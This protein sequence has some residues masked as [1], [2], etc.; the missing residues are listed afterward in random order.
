MAHLEYNDNNITHAPGRTPSLTGSSQHGNSD[1]LELRG[2]LVLDM[3][4][5]TMNVGLAVLA[6]SHA[7][8]TFLLFCAV[9]LS[10]LLTIQ[11]VYT[12]YIMLYTWDRPE[13][14][15][16]AKAPTRFLPPRKSFSVMLP[17]RDE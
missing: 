7:V 8:V 3:G 4:G 11:S 2:E 1:C 6:V 13:A 16:R 5:C 14:S 17:A 15:R 12:L 10:I 9:A